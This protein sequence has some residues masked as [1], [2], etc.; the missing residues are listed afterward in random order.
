[1]V[2]DVTGGGNAFCGGFLAGWCIRPGDLEHAGRCAAASA[3]LAIAQIGLPAATH[4]REA[5]RLAA[6]AQVY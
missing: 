3:A 1:L 2:V 4:L 5:P 6:R